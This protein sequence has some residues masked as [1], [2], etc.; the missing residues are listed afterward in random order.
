MHPCVFWQGH[1]LGCAGQMS[2]LMITLKTLGYI[3]HIPFDRFLYKMW[4]SVYLNHHACV[5][6]HRVGIYRTRGAIADY[7]SISVNNSEYFLNY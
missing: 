2:S 7:F 5:L 1:D 6:M 4:V 3:G